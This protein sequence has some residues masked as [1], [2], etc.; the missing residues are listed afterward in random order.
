MSGILL[1]SAYPP[2]TSTTEL[3]GSYYSIV[4]NTNSGYV[5][6]S[7]YSDTMSGDFT[8]EF[9]A[10]VHTTTGSLFE[11]GQYDRTGILVRLDFNDNG[12][13][14]SFGIS[15]SAG[16]GRFI[17]SN[18]K[19]HSW[20][21]IVLSRNNFQL[22][23][24]VNGSVVGMR[25]NLQVII[26][27]QTTA[28][29]RKGIQINNDLYTNTRR[30]NGFISN[31]RIVN[32]ISLYPPNIQLPSFNLSTTAKTVFFL[33]SS[34][35]NN[36]NNTTIIDESPQ[37]LSV[38]ASANIT[39]SYFTPFITD[40][41]WSMFFNNNYLTVPAN[42]AINFQSSDFTIEFWVYRTSS[43]LGTA[44]SMARNQSGSG[45]G[46]VRIDFQSNL[47]VRPLIGNS[48][49]TAWASTATGTTVAPLNTWVHY[50]LVKTGTTIKQYINGALDMT[51]TGIPASFADVSRD[52]TIGYNNTTDVQYFTGYIS[53]LRVVKGTAVYTANF[54]L[55]TTPLTNITNTSLLCCQSSIFK[56]NSSNNFT[57][58]PFSTTNTPRITTYIPFNSQV[59]TK[60]TELDKG[61]SVLINGASQLTI[62]DN[63]PLELANN[64]FTLEAW[65]Y[66]FNVSGVQAILA[67]WLGPSYPF[68]F[69]TNNGYIT[70]AVNNSFYAG[71]DRGLLT[72][73]TWNHVALVRSGNDWNFF[74][75]GV[76]VNTRTNSITVNNDGTN[77]VIGV[78]PDGGGVHRFQGY[79]SN[80]RLIRSSVLYTGNFNVP[81]APLTVLSGTSLLT[82][83]GYS[84]KDY[85]TNNLTVTAV[86]GARFSNANPFISI[87]P[88]SIYFNGNNSLSITG[89]SATNFAGVDWTVEF[90]YY[91]TSVPPV[92]PGYGGIFAAVGGSVTSPFLSDLAILLNSNL[93]VAA[94]INRTKYDSTQQ[95]FLYS[96]NKIVLHRSN[97][98]VQLIL[99]GNSTTLV[100]ADI[101]NSNL[102]FHIGTE[103]NN[104]WTISG[105]VSNL[106]IVKGTT[107]YI[108]S[109]QLPTT[110]LTN[111]TNTA[112]LTCQN[113][114]FVDNSTNNLL[115]S[116]F[117]NA[118][119]NIF[120]PFK[121]YKPAY[122]VYFG[123][124]GDYL[125]VPSN[126]AF[127]FGTGDFTIEAWVNWTSMPSN[128]YIFDLGANNGTVHYNNN[129]LRYYN[130]AITTSVL[131]TTGF[132]SNLQIN[133]WYHIA[134][135]RRSGSTSLYLNGTQSVTAGDFYNF[136]VQSMTIGNHGLGGNFFHSGYISNIRVVKGTAVY[137]SNFALPT[138]PLTA[139]TNTVLLTCNSSTF[140][141]SSASNFAI[142]KNGDSRISTASP[143]VGSPS[144][145][146]NSVYF[147]GTGDWLSVSANTAFA[148]GTGDFTVECWVYARATG[149]QAIVGSRTGDTAASIRWGLFVLNTGFL[150]CNIRSTADADIA[151]ITHQTPFVLNQWN[152]CALVR[153]GTEFRL[154]YN[155]VQ[156]ASSATSSAA[157]SNSSTAVRIGDF[158][159]SVI[160][161]LN[162][163][164]SNLRIVKG[165]AVYTANFTP[166]TTPL[167][168]IANTV[169]LTCNSTTLTD[170]S[171][172]G[173]LITKTGEC[174]ITETT[175]FTNA[176]AT[177]YNS[178]Y[179]DGAGDYLTAGTTSS[180]NFLHNS[181]A[182][183]TIEFWVYLTKTQ[184]TSIFSNNG[185]ASAQV[186]TYVGITS[187][188]KLRLFVTRGV[189]ASFVIDFTTNTT[190][191]LNA[192]THI[193]ITYEQSL[194]SM[195]A[196]FYINGIITDAGNKTANTPSSA[197]ATNVAVIGSTIFNGYISNLRIVNSIVSF[198]NTIS[199]PTL[200]PVAAVTNTSLL[201][202]GNNMGMYDLTSLNPLQI[203]GTGA[204]VTSNVDSG[205][206][207]VR[208]LGGKSLSIPADRF[209]NMSSSNDFV[210]EYWMYDMNS[211]PQGNILV[212][213]SGTVLTIL[214]NGEF[215][216]GTTSIF[217]QSSMITS[218]NWIHVAFSRTNGVL[219][220]YINGVITGSAYSGIN[221]N[222]SLTVSIG[223]SYNGLLRNLRIVID[224]TPYTILFTPPN[225]PLPSIA[226]TTLLTHGT[227]TI[228][229]VSG[230]SNV[231]TPTGDVR[232]S[233]F[234]PFGGFGSLY[235]N[236][237]TSGLTLAPNYVTLTGNFT[238]EC[239]VYVTTVNTYSMILSG[240]TND[241]FYLNFNNT[242][243]IG[244]NIGGSN[245][246][247]GTSAVLNQWHHVTW[248]REQNVIRM[249]VNGILEGTTG[250]NSSSV[251]LQT[252]GHNNSSTSRFGGYISNLRIIDT[253]ALYTS[254]FIKPAKPLNSIDNTK[255]LTCN[256]D[257]I[258]NHVDSTQ[259]T[260][261]NTNVTPITSNPFN[262]VEH[263]GNTSNWWSGSS[264]N[265]GIDIPNG[266]VIGDLMILILSASSTGTFTV[267]TDGFKEVIP[268]TQLSPVS[269]GI[270]SKFNTGEATITVRVTDSS[271]TQ[272]TS[273]LV[274]LRNAS[275]VSSSYQNTT[276]TGTNTT[277]VTSSMQ[278][279]PATAVI[280]VLY[281]R[282][283]GTPKSEIVS[284][285]PDVTINTHNINDST[286]SVTLG[287]YIN[288]YYQ[289]LGITYNNRATTGSTIGYT[290]YVQ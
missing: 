233:F 246:Y 254:S 126:A 169:L 32:G 260:I 162:G 167:T 57:I 150:A 45:F 87:D 181:S 267:S 66:Q 249:F 278:T 195:N 84:I 247:S 282:T 4:G 202:N 279:Y 121:T 271:A 237:T 210:I 281:N 16:D 158:D 23:V 146:Y 43:T 183:F 143:F 159:T 151:S 201:L 10:Y 67:K 11:L 86:G 59:K 51:L 46:P 153:N 131:T 107:I 185:G 176:T 262:S 20:N 129:V 26:N 171:S 102:L 209:F 264:T 274:V 89:S 207:S 110:P 229:D 248:T 106:R 76:L 114:T 101:I 270:Y 174:L 137:T 65:I 182:L 273:H 41:Y 128:G 108:I 285:N 141:D 284:P 120:N 125:T 82:C 142:T 130:P 192:W 100:S 175:P 263:V 288:R 70:C 136:G 220:R 81:T 290:F 109:V 79:I 31:F 250:N 168:A 60:V 99:N 115:V 62:P 134:V 88:G 9:W 166:S 272:Y 197:N 265:L 95:I 2:N 235:F 80:L 135:V 39:Q 161:D 103:P 268:R 256:S 140:S 277:I 7:S 42:T 206:Y 188:N 90:W 74:V 40:G 289:Q 259:L 148:F 253:V 240:P 152:H 25:S 47:T 243:S 189:S 164:I 236:G 194:S 19:L 49:N 104:N 193:A 186:G 144:T 116:K 17:S 13:V 160:N 213:S 149:F 241:Q 258:Q 232:T 118:I 269:V 227:D 280:Q 78:N 184:S 14:G 228:I 15:N 245:V 38:T 275:L 178:V 212:T 266:T 30:I 255:L 223:S 225:K 92:S 187:T 239:F 222:T 18:I 276:A 226:G 244:F 112:L 147:D 64:S 219:S 287:I 196:K 199:T 52:I 54:T 191:S 200:S 139:I 234:N 211:S 218:N 105:Y 154:Y 123:G 98:F 172:N 203:V 198:T 56:D 61:S 215:I 50:A 111:I 117:D 156:S 94:S 37:E 73:N 29:S 283:T 242:G 119:T 35:A 216:S 157:I 48:D 208:F 72:A 93:T 63:S 205:V 217:S 133:T 6:A 252:I 261:T 3:Y 55:P 124:A 231:L 21:H 97:G 28:V 58:T 8:I 251:N 22:C 85:S 71:N 214:A 68:Y 165:T 177:L 91:P 138:T 34:L 83:T 132:G 163:Y 77:W 173:F 155:G 230:N 96:W 1:A 5:A 12:F 33:N 224:S 69:Y 204:E 257:V 127:Q 27:P 238:I 170:L 145:S 113:S 75:N 221:F 53:N 24:F 180:F 36:V 179:F 44:Y 286:Y 122:S 190:I